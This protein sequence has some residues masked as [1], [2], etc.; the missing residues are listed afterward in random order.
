[1]TYVHRKAQ[2][3]QIK[4]N[5]NYNMCT[6]AFSGTFGSGI[7]KKKFLATIAVGEFAECKEKIGQLKVIYTILFLFVFSVVIIVF[8]FRKCL[9]ADPHCK[10]N[11]VKVFV[12][13]LV[14]CYFISA[15]LISQ[16]YGFLLFFLRK[17]YYSRTK[18]HDRHVQS[19]NEV[20]K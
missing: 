18:V 13:V 19:K 11:I 3:P 4:V 16:G 20:S 5:V 8:N 14:K 6:S 12:I 17:P 15:K 7:S 9:L 2:V 1:M 10:R